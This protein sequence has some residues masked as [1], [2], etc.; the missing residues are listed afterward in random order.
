MEGQASGSAKVLSQFT[1][2]SIY[3]NDSIICVW[4]IDNVDRC[5]VMLCI[6]VRGM[7]AELL[8]GHLDGLILSILARSPSH[9]YA[10][11]AEVKRLSEAI[12]DLPEGTIY[13]ALHRLEHAGL[14]SSEWSAGV[15]HRRRYI[16]SPGRESS[17]LSGAGRTG[18]SFSLQWRHSTHD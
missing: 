7:N 9:G 2:V 5:K 11:L 17:G 12:F 3:T 8:K 1:P 16:H 13:P 4:R 14:V 18:S 15:P 6:T 10:V